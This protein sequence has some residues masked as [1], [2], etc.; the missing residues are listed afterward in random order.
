[1]HFFDVKFEDLGEDITTES[2]KRTV[3]C[4]QKAAC[5][6]DLGQVSQGVLA[7]SSEALPI[8]TPLCNLDRDQSVAV[9]HSQSLGVRETRN[10]T[11]PTAAKIGG[12]MDLFVFDII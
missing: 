1:M 3:A 12:I 11:P 5:V 8:L 6:S 4:A 10:A 9:W 7:S 2:F